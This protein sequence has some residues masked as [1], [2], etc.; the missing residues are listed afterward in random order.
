MKRFISI[1]LCFLCLTLCFGCAEDAP[2]PQEGTHFYYPLADLSFQPGS[3]CYDGEIRALDPKD[4]VQILNIYF[5]GPES[6]HLR[7]PFPAG[8]LAQQTVLEGDTVYITVSDHLATLTGL[9]LTMAC[10][11]LSLTA[12]ELTGGQR[13]VINAEDALLDGQKSITM[14]KNNLLLADNWQEE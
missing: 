4:W 9:D 14:D 8:L 1:F 13:V 3:T 12:M 2:E 5:A 11:C 7:S 6:E 10:G